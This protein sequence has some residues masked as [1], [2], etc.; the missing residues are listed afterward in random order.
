ME[1]LD[2]ALGLWI[3]AAD[4]AGIRLVD[5]AGHLRQQPVQAEPDGAGDI[6]SD[7]AGDAGLDAPGQAVRI[8]ALPR[9]QGTRDLIHRLPH[10]DGNLAGDLVDQGGAGAGEPIGL[11]RHQQDI[12]AEGARLRHRHDVLHAHSLR[13]ARAGYDAGAFHVRPLQVHRD[14]AHR[15]PAQARVDLL[16]HRGKEAVKV[17]IEGFDSCWQTHGGFPLAVSARPAAMRTT[18]RRES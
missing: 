10:L 17:Q 6:G 2:G 12:G 13:L 3:A 11:L 8:G 9:I 14:H 16:H 4:R 5:L 1:A 7:I 15:P 18:P